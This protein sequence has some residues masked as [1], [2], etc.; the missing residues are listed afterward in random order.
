MYI[1]KLLKNINILYTESNFHIMFVLMFTLVWRQVDL[2][3]LL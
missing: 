1:L 2:Y 3:V